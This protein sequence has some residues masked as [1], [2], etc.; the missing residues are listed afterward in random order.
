M[1]TI[2][3]GSTNQGDFHEG[4][5]F[6]GVHKLPLVCVIINNKYAI[7]VP[8]SLQYA[9]EKL[10][11]RAIGYGIKG[12]TVDGNDPIAVYAAMKEARIRALNGDGPTLIEAVTARMTPHSSD[13]DDQYRSKSIKE[14]LKANDCNVKFKSYLLDTGIIDQTWLDKIENEHKH[15]INQATKDA[16]AADYPNVEEA[17][18]H[19]YEEGS[20]NG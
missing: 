19:V 9:A 2:G 5:N 3:E 11:D 10:S 14:G 4:L 8:D 16:E 6:A 18:T 12:I 7:S 20:K 1:A 13:D 17:Y 15:I